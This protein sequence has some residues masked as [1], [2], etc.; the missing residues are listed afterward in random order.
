MLRALRLVSFRAAVSLR[1]S[2]QQA[3]TGTIT[4]TVT[5][6]SQAAVPQAQVTVRNSAT[7][8]ERT[9]SSG[10]LGIYTITLLPVGEYE[11]TAKKQG[12]AD[13]KV[14]DVKGGVGQSEIG[15]AHV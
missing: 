9:T 15:R 3:L 13:A 4:G 10:E 6:A 14:S 11:V 5:D 7:G 1:A 12:F 8:L 2:A